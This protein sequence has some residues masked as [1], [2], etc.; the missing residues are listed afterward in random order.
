MEFKTEFVPETVGAFLNVPSAVYHSAPG[1]SNSSL[2]SLFR[3]P[4]DYALAKAGLIP[5]E[6]TDAMGYGQV[7]HSI[8]LE[9]KKLEDLCHI[10]PE[11]YGPEKKPWHGGAKECK[12]WVEKHRDR[13]VLDKADADAI[14]TETDYLKG[15]PKMRIL[16]GCMTEVS[17]FARA[18]EPGYL[19]KARFDALKQI[20][21]D[22][23]LIA[24]V[25]TTLDASTHAFSREILKRKY[26]VQAA[27]Y[28]RVLRKL[29]KT[30][31]VSFLFVAL[32]KGKVPKANFRFLSAQAMD[33]GEQEFDSCIDTLKK[34][35]MSGSYPDWTDEEENIGYIDLPDFVYGDTEV[36]TGMTETTQE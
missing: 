33:L 13:I 28:R 29:A 25:K 16:D 7:F 6:Q 23:W 22:S 2:K 20:G 19:I 11:T 3:S 34:C 26:H 30:E 8:V 15:H 5:R 18:C 10:R 14:T 24:D 31:N 32:E 9:N 35:R 21:P 12:E 27:I 17:C 1:E 4:K 36:L